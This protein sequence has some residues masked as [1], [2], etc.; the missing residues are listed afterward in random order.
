MRVL[1]LSKA[2]LVGTYQRKAE[3]L[4]ALPDIELTVAVPPQWIEPNVGATTLER[5][6]VEGY[7]LQVLPM[8]LNGHFHLHWYP[9]LARLIRLVKPDVLHIDEESFNLAT[10][11][12]MRLGVVAGARCCF[13]NYANIDR[14]YPPPFSWFERYNFRHAA[15]GLAANQEAAAILQAHGF[16]GP[17]RVLPQFGVDHEFFHPAPA[18]LPPSPFRIGYFGR[19]VEEKGVLDL[20]EAVARLP[21][22]A[23]LLII[24]SGAHESAIRAA[25]ERLGIGDRVLMRAKVP[26]A[27]IADAMRG[28][29]TFVLPSHTT[30]RWKEQYGRVLP[31]AMASGVPPIGSSSGEIPHVIGDGGLVFQEGDVDDLVRKLRLLMDDPHLHR[32]LAERGRQRV[33]DHYTQQSVARA[34]YEVYR[35]MLDGEVQ[36]IEGAERGKADQ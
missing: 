31:E 18:P 17:L 33:L 35:E 28:L 21:Q 2:M 36:F 8:W 30:P 10:F 7:R 4:A 12:A 26:S 3:E 11:Q 25:I 5:R 1:I 24:G 9:G 19:L 29:H 23:H 32:T 27:E 34:Y 14:R 13:Y 20:V 16:R 6:Y 15:V 22:H